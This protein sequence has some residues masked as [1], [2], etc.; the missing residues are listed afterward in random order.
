[1][2]TRTALVQL[3]KENRDYRTLFK[4][5]ANTSALR[6]RAQAYRFRDELAVCGHVVSLDEVQDALF[7]LAHD[8]LPASP[9]AD[10]VTWAGLLCGDAMARLSEHYANLSLE[11]KEAV[12]L[13][14]AWERNDEIVAAC[15]AED[16]GTL[17]EALSG[18]ER[19]AL[20]AL[21]RAKEQSGAA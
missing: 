10:F 16:L 5:C 11:E 9:G 19:E 17:R 14:A 3:L 18:Y 13:S 12:A 20:A 7:E 2:K 21:D 15:E 1:M 4:R 6:L 8:L